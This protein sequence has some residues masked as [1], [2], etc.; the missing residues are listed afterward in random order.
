MSFLKQYTIRVEGFVTIMAEENLDVNA[1]PMKIDVVT[2][3]E[4]KTSPAID[5]LETDIT[6]QSIQSVTDNLK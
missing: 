2:R 5:L 1:V 4:D 3:D 6:E